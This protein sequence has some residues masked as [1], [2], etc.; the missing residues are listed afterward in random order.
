MRYNFL[1]KV[2][3]QSDITMKKIAT[4]ENPIDMLTKLF[5]ILKFNY[6]M[7]LVGVCSLLLPLGDV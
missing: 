4:A 5:S 7:D 1:Q 6:C 2:V 3:T